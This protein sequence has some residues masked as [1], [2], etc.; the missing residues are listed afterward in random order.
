VEVATEN[1]T[2]DEGVP[3]SVAGW[4]GDNG[5]MP[6]HRRADPA[7]TLGVRDLA[8]EAVLLAGGARAILL[9]LALPEVGAGVARHSAFAADPI[10]RLRATMTY[11]YAVVYGTREE[12]REVRRRVNL[13]HVPVNGDAPSYDAY[14]PRLQLWVVATLY[15]TGITL[16]ERIFGRLDEASADRVYREYGRLGTT[17][18]VPEGHWPPDRAAFARYWA[19]M[20]PRL[21]V[22]PESARVAR[23]LLRPTAAPPLLRA[24]MPLVALVTAG[25]LPP[26]LRD[27]FG[28]RW[29]SRL[30]RRFERWMRAVGSVYRR[31]P[32]PLRHRLAIVYLRRLRGEL[33][34]R[35]GSGAGRA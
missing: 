24:L 9:Q 26:V 2:P 21:T 12:V 5:S 23:E 13:A 17:L 27:G 25:L 15:D 22:T 11:V 29:D 30:Q 18:Q 20:L 10:S 28:M 6:R 8:A 34:G 16:Y 35:V 19:Q 32:R 4:Q 1:S 7:S 33:R 31:L 3:S 14:D